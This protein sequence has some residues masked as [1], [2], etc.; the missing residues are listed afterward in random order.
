MCSSYPSISCYKTIYVYP[1]SC[2]LPLTDGN[3]WTAT[4][5]QQA[6]VIASNAPKDT[7]IILLYPGHYVSDKGRLHV[8]SNVVELS[9]SNGKAHLKKVDLIV[10]VVDT[11]TGLTLKSLEW[12]RLTICSSSSL[13]L[14]SSLRTK[15]TIQE[16]ILQRFVLQLSDSP[17]NNILQILFQSVQFISSF[18]CQTHR[19]PMFGIYSSPSVCRSATTGEGRPPQVCLQQ[20]E[21]TDGSLFYDIQLNKTDSIDMI[22]Q[23]CTFFNIRQRYFVHLR[24]QT[25]LNWIS[26]NNSFKNDS[27]AVIEK[28]RDCFL[29]DQS[30]FKSYSSQ[31]VTQLSL[32]TPG[33]LYLF[34]LYHQ[35]QLLFDGKSHTVENIQ[36][37]MSSALEQ[38]YTYG[39]SR[40]QKRHCDGNY[41]I[42]GIYGFHESFDS[43]QILKYSTNNIFKQTRDTFGLFCRYLARHESILQIEQQQNMYQ[44]TQPSPSNSNVINT[45]DMVSS[46]GANTAS[47]FEVG[48]LDLSSTTSLT[49]T[50]CSYNIHIVIPEEI[51]SEEKVAQITVSE[52]VEPT[53]AV[54]NVAGTKSNTASNADSITTGGTYSMSGNTMTMSPV[55]SGST[56]P[57][58]KSGSVMYPIRQSS[59]Y[60]SLTVYSTTY[61]LFNFN[62]SIIK[63]NQYPWLNSNQSQN[64]ITGCQ[65]VSLSDSQPDIEEPRMKLLNSKLLTS[66]SSFDSN[67]HSI[68]SLSQSLSQ[69]LSSAC[70]IDSPLSSIVRLQSDKEGTSSSFQSVSGLYIIKTPS[71]SYRGCI[72]SSEQGLSENERHQ[73]TLISNS[74]ESEKLIVSID[75]NSRSSVFRKTDIIT[76]ESSG[77]VG[78]NKAKGVIKTIPNTLSS[79]LSP[80]VNKPVSKL[81]IKNKN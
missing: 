39:E 32:G 51:S 64:V 59:M 13:S 24:E 18:S 17:S 2:P 9:T 46:D 25:T 66:S 34:R 5:L 77:Y 78:T 21:M 45:K 56:T 65:F 61:F 35:S 76:S 67:Y 22:E 60:K 71:T 7:F 52:S 28:F 37:D 54:F 36:T 33:I 42:N 80:I 38:I 16:S 19:K 49:D 4:S 44:I 75:T 12:R 41:S 50:A 43:S 69:H 53:A 1:S 47:I 70:R 8:P 79:L 74:M 23:N 26:N 10:T 30:V 20:C 62:S 29:E 27:E 48:Q 15:I 31:N 11:N 58:S 68:L 81:K 6:F 73:I 40:F 55:F 14:S 72:I 63:S 57:V 3:E